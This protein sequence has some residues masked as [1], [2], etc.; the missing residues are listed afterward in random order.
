M[1]SRPEMKHRFFHRANLL[2]AGLQP[3]L[4]PERLNV[5]PKD[6]FVAMGCPR[7]HPYYCASGDL[8]AGDAGASGRHNALEVGGGSWVHT[9]GL[10]D[11]GVQVVKLLS[12]G[13]VDVAF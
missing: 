12:G 1:I 5:F 11:A 13:E 3:S 9:K 10:L 6:L 2:I 4:R 8:L 7:A